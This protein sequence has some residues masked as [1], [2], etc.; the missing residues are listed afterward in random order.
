[1]R[2]NYEF[3]ITGF[4]IALLAMSLIAS[5][6]GI[7]IVQL[8]DTYDIQGNDTLSKYDFTEEIRN[9]T[10]SIR[11]ATDIAPKTGILDVVGGYF[12]SGFAAMKT[13]WASFELFDTMMNDPEY[14]SGDLEFISKFKINTFL[15]LFVVIGLFI[16]VA[17]AALV[18]WRL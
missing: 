16:G 4:I 5:A 13:S 18:K 11:N 3:T 2:A 8:D 9:N 14:V 10:Q 15:F 12:S 6:F 7:F 17:I 1:M